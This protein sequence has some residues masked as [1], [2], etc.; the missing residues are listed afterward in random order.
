MSD[1]KRSINKLGLSARGKQELLKHL[2]GKKLNSTQRLRAKCYSCM[3]YYADGK[4]DC[5]VPECPLYPKMPY[6]SKTHSEIPLESP[7]PPEFD[8]SGDK[9]PEPDPK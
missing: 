4:M 8:H 1:I 5:Q 6:R 9:M 7:D 2:G 3:G